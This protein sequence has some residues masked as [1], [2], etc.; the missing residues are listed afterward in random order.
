MTED[1]E[2]QLLADAME[3]ETAYLNTL[4]ML[5]LCAILYPH[6]TLRWEGM[7]EAGWTEVMAVVEFGEPDW[8][9][10][11]TGGGWIPV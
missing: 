11:V 1:K 4:G 3:E 9:T 8:E 7:C 10:A 5:E 2:M 6:A